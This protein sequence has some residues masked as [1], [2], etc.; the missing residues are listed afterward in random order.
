MLPETIAFRRTSSNLAAIC[1][2]AMMTAAEIARFA[3]AQTP[4]EWRVAEQS[5]FET[6]ELNPSPCPNVPGK[7]HY[8]LSC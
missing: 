6:G 1:A 3:S 2:P 4:E 7:V 5:H 8:L